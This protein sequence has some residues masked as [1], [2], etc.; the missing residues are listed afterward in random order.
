MAWI[1]LL[2]DCPSWCLPGHLCRL[3]AMGGIPLV[4]NE[5]LDPAAHGCDGGGGIIVCSDIIVVLCVYGEKLVALHERQ[6]AR[7]FPKTAGSFGK[8]LLL[9][10]ESKVSGER[11]K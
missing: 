10:C 2:H 3:C 4:A 6:N 7:Q 11:I 8:L 1:G 5:H 9:P